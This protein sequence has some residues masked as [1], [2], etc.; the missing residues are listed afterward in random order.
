MSVPSPHGALSLPEELVVLSHLDSGKVRSTRQ[1]AIGCAVAELG[2]LALRRRIAVRPR[3]FTRFGVE[4]HQ[5]GGDIHVLDHRPTGLAWADE[6]LDELRYRSVAERKPLPLAKWL[7]FRG[8]TPLAV[9]RIPLVRGGVL[10]RRSGGYFRC[11][12]HFPDPAAR[13]ALIGGL[14]AAHDGGQVFD[15][16]ALLLSDLVEGVELVDDLGLTPSWRGRVD[17][18]REVGAAEGLRD[19][20]TVLGAAVPSRRD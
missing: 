7:D 14:R 16:R 18:A 13:T 5:R 1:T 17:R 20:G 19:T 4:V 2:E 9:H 6:L 11:E 15:E 8:A 3:R 10:R 12:R